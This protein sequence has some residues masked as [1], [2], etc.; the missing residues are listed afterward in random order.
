M[1]QNQIRPV[2]NNG[3]EGEEVIQVYYRG[4]S[5]GIAPIKSLVGFKR[6]HLRNEQSNT[7]QIELNTDFMQ[8]WSPQAGEYFLPE[9]P[10][11]LYIGSSSEDIRIELP[12]TI[13]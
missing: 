3:S 12:Y 11:T 8:S 6:I 13:E 5:R 4:P 10:S 9:G 2:K 7:V 1:G